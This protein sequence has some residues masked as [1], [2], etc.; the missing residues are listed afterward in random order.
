MI[1]ERNRLPP[2]NSPP[3][4]A[5]FHE[6]CASALS[7]LSPSLYRALRSSR[8]LPLSPLRLPISS[9]TR[10]VPISFRIIYFADPHPLTPI[11]SHSYKKGGRGEGTQSNFFRPTQTIPLFSTA[12]KHP[13]HSD[14]RNSFPLKVL[15][16]GSL[17]ALGWGDSPVIARLSFA[18]PTRHFSPKESPRPH[19]FSVGHQPRISHRSSQG[20]CRTQTARKSRAPSPLP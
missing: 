20:E 17:D 6:L 10:S 12:S 1:S 19:P 15:L 5:A 11:E 9:E 4:S 16:H 3:S 8:Q 13:S 14:A 7:C 2:P 18:F